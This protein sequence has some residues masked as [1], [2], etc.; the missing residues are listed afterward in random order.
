MD[1]AAAWV[2][3]ECGTERDEAALVPFDD[4]VEGLD[5]DQFA[6][7]GMLEC[8]DRRVAKAEPAHD[9]I[10]RSR[11]ERREAE[12]SESDFDFVKEARHEEGF[13]QLHLEDLEIVVIGDVT[14]QDARTTIAKWFGEWKTSATRPRLDLPVRHRPPEQWRPG[15]ADRTRDHLP[16]QDRMSST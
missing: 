7:R 10:P 6:H 1:K 4:G 8:R 13:A 14:A 3:A 5:D 11:I 9:D 12:V 15:A 16:G 2:T